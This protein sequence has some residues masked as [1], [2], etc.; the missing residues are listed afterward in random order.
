[1]KKYF[2]VNI[3]KTLKLPWIT[4][5]KKAIQSI[6]LCRN[7]KLRTLTTS[8]QQQLIQTEIDN[9]SVYDE[10]KRASE[11]A[12]EIGE[13]LFLSAVKAECL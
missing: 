7:Q 9:G 2:T 6:H 13:T 8:L 4:I 10:M 12:A 1:V 3:M 5:L 11:R